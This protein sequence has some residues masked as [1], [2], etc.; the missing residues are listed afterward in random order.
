MPE[1]PECKTTVDYLNKNLQGKIIKDWVFCG[2][3]YP[4]A[5]PD[6]Y[7]EFSNALPL[8]VK[9]VCCKGKFI[10]FILE[11][12]EG[13]KYYILH[14]LMMTGRWQ[15]TY[16]DY[17]KWFVDLD[18]G[19]TIWFCDSRSFATVKFTTEESILQNK[20]DKLGPDI[21]TKE[22][23]LSIFKKLVKKYMNRNITAF[24]MD[25]EV[26]SGCGNYLKAETL[27]YAK[28]SPLRKMSSLTDREQEILYEG[29]RIIP[30][31]SYNKWGTIIKK[32][33]DEDG[34]CHYSVKELKVYGQGHAKRTKTADG[35]I[36]YWDPKEQV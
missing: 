4:D 32:C 1:G 20:L 6:G 7:I 27:F 10:Y 22:F 18:N 33:L 2:G 14:S 28:I 24:L 15:K 8:M 12:K 5:Y 34:L 26:I 30:R 21:M 9:E 16:N 35:R 29:L 11:D 36:T 3:K 19:K 17:C 25:Q 31:L 13:V 23:T